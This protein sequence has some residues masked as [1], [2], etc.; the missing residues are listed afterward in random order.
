M[1]RIK[2]TNDENIVDNAKFIET[3]GSGDSPL[4]N[5]MKFDQSDGVYRAYLLEITW[6]DNVENK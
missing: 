2:K 5:S 1:A 4:M 3:N 6:K